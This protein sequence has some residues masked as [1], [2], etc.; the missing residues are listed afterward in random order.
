VISNPKL[1]AVTRNPGISCRSGS[2]AFTSNV[3]LSTSNCFSLTTP[4]SSILSLYSSN[5]ITCAARVGGLI[6]AAKRDTATG[7]AARLLKKYYYDLE[8]VPP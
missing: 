1:A 3:I 8:S 6:S 5:R 7:A 2:D 4:L